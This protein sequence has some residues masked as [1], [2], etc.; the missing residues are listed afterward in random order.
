MRC[1]S[2]PV[3]NSPDVKNS[4]GIMTPEILNRI[5]EKATSECK[6]NGVRLFNWTEPFLH[7]Q[8][9]KMVE[10]VK[11]HRLRCVISTNLNTNSSPCYRRLLESGL[12]ILRISLSA[13]NQEKYG[14]IHRGG[15]IANVKKNLELLLRLREE[16]KSRT[17][18]FVTFH[19][20]LSNLDQESVIAAYCKSKRILFQPINALMLPLEKV[21]A[22]C[23]EAS[24]GE[25]C[26]A[27]MG[28]IDSLALPLKGALASGTKTQSERCKLRE[29]Q[30]VLN[31]RGDV[32]LCCAVYDEKQ[33]KIGNYL[34][35]DLETLQKARSEHKA[36]PFCLKCGVANYFTY[37]I[38]DMNT[39]AAENIRR[40]F[41]ELQEVNN[42]PKFF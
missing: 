29:E 17:R 35:K 11:K 30:M 39:L 38:P 22:Y 18:F 3:G 24:F 6:V 33:F 34:E 14:K 37:N 31:W 4:A 2:C 42:A 26:K 19:R 27:D 40:H 1:P 25:I 15:N 21:L 13:F 28:L 20:Y 9:D 23:Q 10:T 5:L 8:V 16:T 36:C 32:L 41:H 12:D 7:P